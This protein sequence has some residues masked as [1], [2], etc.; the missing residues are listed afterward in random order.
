MFLVLVNAWALLWLFLYAH[1][2]SKLRI[3]ESG[4]GGT[5]YAE[6]GPTRIE[7]DDMYRAAR[8]GRR[9]VGWSLFFTVVALVDW[10]PTK[11]PLSI[12]ETALVAENILICF[13]L[14]VLIARLE[15]IRRS[16]RPSAQ[17]AQVVAH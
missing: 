10:L 13:L 16:Y 7:G 4:A 12:W 11:R 3:I 14:V 9:R 17:P 15:K 6:V 1:W 5:A 8:G 2:F